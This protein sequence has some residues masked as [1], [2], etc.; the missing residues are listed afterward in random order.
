MDFF[1]IINA[2]CSV[3]AWLIVM[4]IIWALAPYASKLIHVVQ[5]VHD[6]AK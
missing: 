3:I 4:A 1:K 2:I 5:T 6:F